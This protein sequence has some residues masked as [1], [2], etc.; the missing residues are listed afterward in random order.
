MRLCW[1]PPDLSLGR[2]RGGHQKKSF[3]TP[4]KTE[5]MPPRTF[6]PL[7]RICVC[8]YSTKIHSIDGCPLESVL[9][10]LSAITILMTMAQ[11]KIRIMISSRCKTSFLY[12]G[13]SQPL[14]KVREDLKKELLTC[15]LFGK[16]L[17]EVWINEDAPPAGLEKN[18]WD[19]CLW[20]AQE[21]DVFIVIY[22]GDAGWP[23]GK[24]GN[25]ICHEEL[26]AALND[27]RAKIRVVELSPLVPLTKDGEGD[28]CSRFRDF[29]T[30]QLPFYGVEA[31]TGEAII[32]RCKEAIHQCLVDLVKLGG[33]EAQK[34]RFY[35]GEALN[36]SR[37]SFHDR[38]E[39][40][41]RALTQSLLDSN[42]VNLGR[43][44]IALRLKGQDK[45]VLL[46]C[47]AI[48]A[49]WSVAGAR[50]LV[51]Q[52]FL[53]DHELV[54][55]M[56]EQKLCGP[57]HV[58]LCHRTV[59]ERQAVGMVGC[60]DVTVLAPPFGIFLADNIQK[61]QLLLIKNCR[62]VTSTRRGIQGAIQWLETT[63]EAE[64]LM[65]RAAARTKILGVIQEQLK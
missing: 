26:E 6:I 52:P 46:R 37:L 44:T 10:K 16:L 21:A 5:I 2:A 63:G 8:D 42:G 61:T 20:Q 22:N 64:H 39:Q 3:P 9:E 54:D 29:V 62:D 23:N 25:G 17:L 51:G 40:M 18:L 28:R 45:S 38:R 34:A 14:S 12:K 24:A 43:E 35:T 1:R 11:D 33:E 65:T 32:Q 53:R 13:K 19:H 36:W 56:K 30:K 15:A 50:E 57:V 49:A 58:I 60:P 4:L 41:R 31:T 7:L 47:D 55:Q 27:S 59:T 48:P